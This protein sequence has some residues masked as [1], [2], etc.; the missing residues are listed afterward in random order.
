MCEPVKVARH[1]LSDEVGG[2]ALRV[3]WTFAFVVLVRAVA[4]VFGPLA[5]VLP[6]V[7]VVAVVGVVV[8]ALMAVAS[9]RAA[10]RRVRASVP[11]VTR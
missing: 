1:S 10:R 2:T 7:A 8:A 4:A 5:L 3:V 9:D 6:A 11:A